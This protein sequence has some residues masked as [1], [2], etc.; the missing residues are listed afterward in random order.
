MNATEIRVDYASI[1][2]SLADL[3]RGEHLQGDEAVTR[4]ALWNVIAHAW[5]RAAQTEASETLSRVAAKVPQ[6]TIVVRAEP[7]APPDIAAWISANCHMV[8]GEKQVCSEE[9]A[10][11]AGGA[12]VD[13][14]PPLVN[15]LLIPDMPVAVWWNGDLP[16]NRHAYLDDLF[17]AADRL[18]V[19]SAHFQSAAD[20]TIVSRIAKKTRTAPADLNWLRLEEWRI[21]TAALF[22]PPAMRA[23]LGEIRSARIALSNTMQSILYLAWLVAQA[24]EMFEFQVVDGPQ[25]VDI[26]FSDGRTASMVCD[27]DRKV[28][29]SQC[30][31]EAQ[32]ECVTRVAPRSLDDL[33]IRQLKRPEADRVFIRAVPIAM[34]LAEDLGL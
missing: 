32:L 18:I 34:K 15:A 29:V 2:K 27:D 1:E 13:R 24:G 14:V 8:G 3:W 9:V 11:V 22:D 6:R 17:E 7:D 31:I 12:L 16:N 21:A 20:L 30:D 19:D 26:V 5:D 25:R 23:R 33:L 4:A 10:I 28:I